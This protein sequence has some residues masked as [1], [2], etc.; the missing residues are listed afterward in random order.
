MPRIP[1]NLPGRSTTMMTGVMDHTT[2]V[3]RS[4][5]SEEWTTCHD[6]ESVTAKTQLKAGTLRRLV[7]QV[8]ESGET[9]T[10]RLETSDH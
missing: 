9:Q 6:L 4:A 2:A 1:H 7:K 8:E 5:M 10:L 3:D